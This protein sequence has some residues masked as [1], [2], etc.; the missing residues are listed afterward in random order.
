MSIF[1]KVWK[2]IVPEKHE[3]P[4]TKTKALK[5]T[6][7]QWDSIARLGLPFK[8]KNGFA[9]NCVCCE[10]VIQK[11]YGVKWRNNVDTPYMC[12]TKTSLRNGTL[13]CVSSCP[14]KD[15]WPN[16]CEAYGSP[17]QEWGKNH[18]NCLNK[19]N[20]RKIADFAKKQIKWWM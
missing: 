1:K 17:Y 4:M 9:Y 13:K 19:Y 14:L 16:G 12:S 2:C 7:R 3:K 5:E 8:R 18:S 20:A 6:Y 10:Y 15:L 11:E